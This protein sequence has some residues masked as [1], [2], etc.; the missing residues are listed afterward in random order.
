MMTSVGPARSESTGPGSLRDAA[1]GLAL[2]RL[3]VG[4]MFLWVFFENLGN[5]F[6]GIPVSHL[7]G[8]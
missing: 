3:T 8:T 7:R 4:S 1:N 2:V 6:C 5:S